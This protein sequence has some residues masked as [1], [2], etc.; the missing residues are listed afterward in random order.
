[1]RLPP[2]AVR[3][4]VLAPL[5][6]LVTVT[7]FLFFPLVLIGAAFAVRWLPGRWRALRLLWVLLVYLGRETIGLVALAILWVFSGFGWRLGSDRFVRAHTALA[8]W[9]VGGLVG[10]ARRV[11]GLRIATECIPEGLKVRDPLRVD[12]GTQGPPVG[13]DR[14]VLV[15]S[16][17]AGAGDSFLLVDALVNRFGRRPRIV[18]KEALRWDPCV[19]VALGRIPSRFVPASRQGRSAVVDSISELASGL[20]AQGALVLFPEGGNFTSRRRTRA[21]QRLREEGLDHLVGKAEELT[22]LLP[23]R[24]GGAFAAID[25]APGADVVFV[26]HS[27]LEQLSSPRQLW[28]GLPM[29]SEVQMAWWKVGAADVPACHEERIEWLYAWW[30]HIDTWIQGHHPADAPVG[31]IG[32]A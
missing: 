24:F 3:R 25:A 21:I 32:T 6:C 1:M 11:L 5:M 4:L 15:F 10:S 7:L 13:A 17:H 12:A 30:E 16:R 19:D 26:A 20:S 18:L 2:V 8:G 22:H 29:R 28:N 27:G 9:F 31:P 23:P 14:P